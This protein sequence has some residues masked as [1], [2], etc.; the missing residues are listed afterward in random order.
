ML[1]AGIL[2]LA[3]GT[4][5]AAKGCMMEMV[6]PEKKADALSAIALVE[7]SFDPSFGSMSALLRFADV[8]P[9][10]VLW[11]QTFAMISTISIFGEVFAE[12]S[13]LEQPN[14][15]FFLNGVSFLLALFS[16]F[17]STF[18]ESISD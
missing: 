4:A 3:S 14:S 17:L 12:L 11:K 6:P 15:V 8:L 7:V 13:E 16:R 10:L 5:P 18:L 2:P 1:A 9:T